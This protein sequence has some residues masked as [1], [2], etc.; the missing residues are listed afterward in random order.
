MGGAV[1]PVNMIAQPPLADRPA[2]GRSSG[3]DR[4]WGPRN[5]LEWWLL[6]GLVLLI[7][8]PFSCRRRENTGETIVRFWCRA[9]PNERQLFAEVA[10]DFE[11][12]H[13]KIKVKIESPG[14]GLNKI[15]TAMQAGCCGDVLY[16]H[17]NTIPTLA[18]KR[19]LVR[20]DPIVQRDDYALDDFFPGGIEAY[21][22]QGGLYAL[23]FQGSTMVLFYNQDLFDAAG[24]AYPTDQWTWND[25]LAAA[26]QLTRFD[27]SGRMVQVGCLPYDPATWVWSGGG[28]YLDDTSAKLYFTQPE[29]ISALEFYANLRNRWQVT[30]RNMNLLGADPM[31]VDIFERG[32]VGMDIS[33]P[34]RL[35]QYVA[36]RAK[37]DIRWEIEL[38]PKGPAGRQTRYAGMGI[39]VWADSP[40]REQ[41]WAFAKFLCERKAMT[42]FSKG[43]ADIPARRSVA[44]DTF[45]A[46]KAP[47]NVQVLLKSMEPENGRVRVYPRTELWDD[48]VRFFNVEY[49]LA[50]LGRKSVAE[51]MHAVEA[52]TRRHMA[53]KE[54]RACPA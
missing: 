40:C 31:A 51:A 6:A 28:G 50:L 27:A 33:G 29:T 52:K 9:Q 13:P 26:K 45:G 2:S 48:V 46:Q 1:I 12:A 8:L 15:L 32:Q 10:R 19:C 3:K 16:L 37:R 47:F 21:G 54:A 30:T 34:R 49:G 39:G 25:F 4:S 17:W 36:A 22:Y 41:A 14:V 44:Y 42:H 20:L 11:L 35:P 7:L 23:P 43:W 24:L 53:E 5:A 18:S 38:M